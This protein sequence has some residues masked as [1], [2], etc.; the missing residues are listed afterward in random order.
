MF[1]LFIAVLLSYS[2]S[3]PHITHRR[4]VIH[5]SLCNSPSHSLLLS[6]N[7]FVLFMF[8][9]SFFS[10]FQLCHSTTLHFFP[11]FGL[12]IMCFIKKKKNLH[13]FG[14]SLHNLQYHLFVVS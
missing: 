10:S 6:P 11:L 14:S 8:P 4:I 7:F 1:V 12:T 9:L 3:Y 5:S 13:V 2:T